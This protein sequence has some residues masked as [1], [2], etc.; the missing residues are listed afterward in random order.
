M[1]TSP[2]VA[3]V[4]RGLSP[5]PVLIQTGWAAQMVQVSVGENNGI[6][7]AGVKPQFLVA[8]GILSLEHTAVYRHP[9][10]V[11]LHEMAGS[12]DH[13]CRSHK[14]HARQGIRPQYLAPAMHRANYGQPPGTSGQPVTPVPAQIAAT[15]SR[16][17]QPEPAC[18]P[19]WLGQAVFRPASPAAPY[20]NWMRSA[21]GAASV[22]SLPL[23]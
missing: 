2:A 20:D 7:G 22:T 4:P 15:R 5:V 21:G 6:D 1:P 8:A 11:K 9:G 14:V 10:R 3:G 23:A 12:G 18:C 13:T 16:I 17:R 19:G